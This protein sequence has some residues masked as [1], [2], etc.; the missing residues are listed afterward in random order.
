MREQEML[1]YVRSQG[2]VPSVL[3]ATATE[4]HPIFVAPFRCKIP[5]DGVNFVP[6]AA[7]TG[8]NSNTK[9]LNVVNK[10]AAGAGTTEVG[11][12][13]LTTGVDLVA[14][15]KTAITLTA[16]TVLEAGDVLALQVEK[17]GT[18]VLLPN[19]HFEISFK[20]AAEA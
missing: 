18:G 6:Q 16:A 20:K 9:N 17:V 15:D 2:F 13:D 14:F 4:A 7:V 5:V 11:H 12:K 19:L 1:G 10:G 3:A 8:D